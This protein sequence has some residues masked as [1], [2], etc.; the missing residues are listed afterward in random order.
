M[1]KLASCAAS[2]GIPSVILSY[3]M[4]VTNYHGGAAMTTALSAL[5][6]G[7]MKKGI[8]TLLGIGCAAG[9]LT[10]AAIEWITLKIVLYQ[11]DNGTPKEALEEN[12][13]RLPI[14]KNLKARIKT[15]LYEY[16]APEALMT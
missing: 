4:S 5:G 7:N 1:E 3:A 13:N 11:C 9:C 15:E 10:E 8:A 12:I 6:G 2:I 16:D 14:S